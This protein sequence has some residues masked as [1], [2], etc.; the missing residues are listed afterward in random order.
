[1]P[2]SILE[3]EALQHA[4]LDRLP[5]Q[6]TESRQFS[7]DLLQIALRYGVAASTS[8]VLDAVRAAD[9]G[10]ADEIRLAHQA[11]NDAHAKLRA[12]QGDL[13]EHLLPGSTAAGE[14]I[15]RRVREST[16]RAIEEALQDHAEDLKAPV[17]PE[18]AELWTRLGGVLPVA[19]R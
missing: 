10:R 9:L 6:P 7:N 13:M 12:S 16:D 3:P 4:D 19:D 15:D 5:W 14:E 8:I 2:R 18:L 1:M 11:S 17:L